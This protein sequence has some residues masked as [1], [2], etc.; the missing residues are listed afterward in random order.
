MSG[1]TSELRLFHVKVG[2]EKAQS[3]WRKIMKDHTPLGPGTCVSDPNEEFLVKHDARI[4]AE[5]RKA[6]PLALFSE[7]VLD[8]EVD[9]LAQNIRVK[10]WIS[11]QKRSITHPKAYIRAIAHTTAVDMVRRYRP[12]VSLSGDAD[13]ELCLCDFLVAQNEGFRDPAYEIELR[14]IDPDLLTNLVDAI[15]TLPPRQRQAMFSVLREHRDDV[16]PLINAFK[17]REIDVEEINSPDEACEEYLL[18]ASLSV[19]R[20]KLQWLL[21]DV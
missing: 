21:I 16:L 5:A 18:K 19:A 10:L 15:L 12:E 1:S 3:P 14:E 9:E 2:T 17:A 8:L 11:R 20:K 7:D 6:F 4:L 13:G